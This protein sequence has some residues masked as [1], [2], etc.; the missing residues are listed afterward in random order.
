VEAVKYVF[1]NRW[2][3]L[4]VLFIARFAL[5]FQF[6]SAGS[7]TPFMVQDFG[8]DYTGVGTLVGLY[9]IPGL[10]LTVPSGFIG[11][12]FGDKR[13]VLLGLTMMVLGGVLAGAAD[14][15]TMVATGRLMSG[16]GAAVLFVL[17]TKMVTDWFV[18]KELF[19][20]MSV[21]I[22]GW[23]IGIAAGQA[24]QASIAEAS[25]W[26]VV[27]YMTA[28]GCV[29]ALLAISALYRPPSNLVDGATGSFSALSWRELL[30]VTIAGLVWMFINGAYLVL[31]SFAPVFLQEQGVS[32]VAAGR[33]VSLMSWVFLFSLP[34]GGY[35]ATRFRAPNVVMFT[36]LAGTV[37]VGALIP[38]TDVPF[39]TFTLFGIL[40]AASAP[41]V[42]SLPA[43]VLRPETRGPGFGIY[44]IWYFV[45]SAFLPVVGGYLK[46]ITGTAASSILFGVAM[47]IAT[48]TLVG[49]FRLTQAYVPVRAGSD[50]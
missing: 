6:Q 17:M 28:L 5:G 37:V 38:F 29:I 44:F 36:G 33:V 20:G 15:Y 43:E 47:M 18:D 12:R 14:N 16:A 30:L 31:L 13:I 4:G 34:L 32:F 22:I 23:P 19:L 3:I 2:F 40:Y 35:L 26:N 50:T 41:V 1:I 11:R 46:D 42:A 48:F 7:V 27:F 10:F 8:V 21:F 39:V 49:L 25:S 24:V 45:G 9:M